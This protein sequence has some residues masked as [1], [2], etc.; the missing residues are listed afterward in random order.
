MLS[1]YD[2]TLFRQIVDVAPSALLLVDRERKVVLANRSTERL[3]GYTSDELL[4]REIELLLPERFRRS[5]PQQIA[6]FYQ[7]P[8]TRP[9]GS[10]RELYGRRKYGSEIPIEIG[11]NPMGPP[12]GALTLASIVDVSE[13]RRQEQALRQ[14][15]SALA[16][17]SATL[18][19]QVAE[20]TTQLQATERHLQTILDTLPSMVGYW[21]KDLLNRFANRAYHE[22]FG[23]DALSL[24]GRHLSE[25]LGPQLFEQNRPFLEAVLRGESQTFE[26]AI[27]R[28]SGSGARH[29]LAHYLPDI[30]AGEVRGFHALVH[31]VT[32]ITESRE[33]LAQALEEREVMVLEIHH[34]VK[35]NLQVISSLLNLQLRRMEATEARDA[36][37]DC[38]R[39]VMAIA[40]VH[41]QLYQT[42]DYARVQFGEYLR[43][44]A[45]NVFELG[46][47]ST[48]AR[49]ELAVDDVVLDVGLAIPCALVINELIT[50]ALKHAFP[51]GRAGT[52]RVAFARNGRELQLEVADDGV[53]LPAG[54][55]LSKSMSMGF[56]VVRALTAQLDGVLE[57]ESRIGTLF[58]M[59]FAEGTRGTPSQA[60]AP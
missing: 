49:L 35:N 23:V 37:E 51:G 6:A 7:E 15:H 41:D 53:G 20:R 60:V 2:D 59:T 11:L 19:R 28:V 34:R 48:P 52:V 38:Q 12:H 31:D 36:L 44:L 33:R 45:H 58:R 10:G 8:Q 21:D 32:E 13:R 39:R 46:R 27:P 1:G 42:R 22:W 3:F 25:L 43:T 30:E 17:L 29:S 18:E 24:P 26:R 54:F 16:S 5:H 4:G 50:N 57:V 47:A 14:S 55:E 56:Q 40:L 9:M